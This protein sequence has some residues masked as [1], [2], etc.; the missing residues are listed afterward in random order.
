MQTI[1]E[2]YE[3]FGGAAEIGRAIGKSTEHAAIM[4]RR[5]SIPVEYWLRLTEAARER[6]IPGVTCESLTVMHQPQQAAAS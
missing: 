1:D 5:G 6:G 2:L 3:A 4:K